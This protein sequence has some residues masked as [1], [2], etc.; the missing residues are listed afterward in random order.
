MKKIL[1]LLFISTISLGCDDGNITVENIDFP[2]D[3]TA[4]K[5]PTSNILYLLNNNEALI[6]QFTDAANL[7]GLFINDNGSTTL[8]ITATNRVVYRFYNGKVT[9]ENFCGG[10]T[11][12]PIF[13]VATGEWIATSGTINVATI[14]VL[15]APNGVNGG[16]KITG[17]THTISLKNVDFVRQDGVHQQY[18]NFAF[19]NYSTPANNLPF[20]FLTLENAGFC[21]TSALIYNGIENGVEGLTIQ[22]ISPTLLQNMEGVRREAITPEVNILKYRLFI[23]PYV[24]FPA[25]FFCGPA[26]LMAGAEIYTGIPTAGDVND[27]LATGIIEVTTTAVGSVFRHTVVLKRASFQRNNSTSTFYLGDTFDFGVIITN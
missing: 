11:I 20:N 16:T 17:Y 24:G 4:S 19:G 27:P 1:L 25:D 3:A 21:P 22:N 26:F 8:P 5:C 6:I 7:N 9:A 14:Q 12:P 10:G 15:S 13:P 18:E 2:Q 23:A